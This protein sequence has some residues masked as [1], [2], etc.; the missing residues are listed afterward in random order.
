MLDLRFEYAIDILKAYEDEGKWIVEGFAATTDFD[1][2]EDVISQE[3]IKGSAKDL[4]EN[5][6]VLLNHSANEPIGKVLASEAQKGGLFLK[7]LVSKTVPDIW[8]KIKEGVL[9]KFSVRGM[10]LEAKKQW[11][12]ALQKYARLILKMRLVEVSL[13]AVPANPKARAIRW[14]IEKAMDEFEAKGGK[15]GKAEGGIAMAEEIREEVE[16]LLEG[17]GSGEGGKAEGDGK[18]AEEGI[19]KADGGEGKAPPELKQIL[20]LVDRLIANEEDEGRKK[21]LTQIREIAAGTASKADETPPGD[22]GI[23]KTGRKIASARLSRLKKLLEELQAFVRE[24]DPGETEG[25]QA[26]PTS[27]ELG[28]RFD[29]LQGSVKAIS[30]ALG[31]AEGKPPE[32]LAKAVTGLSKRLETLEGKAG[33]RA[34]LDGQEALAGAGKGGDKSMWKGLL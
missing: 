15:I 27:G 11:M 8:Q 28:K 14:Y 9:N 18:P 30:E 31:L 33:A 7:I 6:T 20:R 23:E 16:V 5:S 32:P 2:Q 3:A 12:P 17:S 22:P 13:V 29:D 10:I 4:I 1:L 34:S 21:V 19:E 26:E 24:V 25:G